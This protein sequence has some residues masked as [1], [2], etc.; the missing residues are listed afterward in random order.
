M[1]I[2]DEKY[3][4]QTSAITVFF[5]RGHANTYCSRKVCGVNFV[6]Y[7]CACVCACL[8]ILNVAAKPGSVYCGTFT[9]F[10]NIFSFLCSFLLLMVSW[11][12]VIG[13]EEA[14]DG[15]TINPNPL[16][17]AP[18]LATAYSFPITFLKGTRSPIR[19]QVTAILDT[20]GQNNSE[21]HGYMYVYTKEL[22]QF[23]NMKRLT[24]EGMRP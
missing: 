9:P 23:F 6:L 10:F 24:Y 18:E 4:L 21:L 14:V 8:C 12:A 11:S 7:Q 17:S 1:H 2:L 15:N 3:L 22:E 16:W 13:W 20:A 19:T 5:K